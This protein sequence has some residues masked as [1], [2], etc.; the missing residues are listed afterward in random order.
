ML[1]PEREVSGVWSEEC[2]ILGRLCP[3][4]THSNMPEMKAVARTLRKEREDGLDW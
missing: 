2:V 1:G 3:R 4:M